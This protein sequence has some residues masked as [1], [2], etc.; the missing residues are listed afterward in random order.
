MALVEYRLK[1]LS[2]R[3]FGMNSDSF[4]AFI[5]ATNT[6]MFATH[7]ANFRFDLLAFNLDSCAFR[8]LWFIQRRIFTNL[9]QRRRWGFTSLESLVAFLEADLGAAEGARSRMRPKE[10][11]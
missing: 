1:H 3:A 4:F 11:L 8:F 6:G 5:F 2:G 10:E 9:H 7:W